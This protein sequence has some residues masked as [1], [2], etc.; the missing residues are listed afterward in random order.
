MRSLIRLSGTFSRGEK[1]R[2]HGGFDDAPIESLAD[3]IGGDETEAFERAVSGERGGVVPPVHDEIGRLGDFRPARTQG[4]GI[5]IAKCGAHRAGTDKRRIAHHEIR[6]RPCRL[7]RVHITLQRH[8]GAVIGDGESSHWRGFGGDAIPAHMRHAVFIGEVFH[9]V[10]SQHG[11][12]V[13][14]IA[15][16]ADHRLRRRDVALGAEVPLQVADPQHHFSDGGGT[17]IQFDTEQLVRIDGF[18]AGRIGA[19]AIDGEAALAEADFIECVEHFAFEAFQVFEGDIE[20]IARAAGRI[21]HVQRAQAMVKTAQHADRLLLLAFGGQGEGG[22][23]GIAPL[24]AQRFDH[25][26]QHE[27]LDIGAR[28]VVRAELVPLARI[29][30]AFEQGAEDGRFDV[31][32][33]GACRFDQQGDLFAAQ[34]QRVRTLE[35]LAVESEHIVGDGG[36]ESALVHVLPED[37]EHAHGG[38]RILRMLDQQ[39]AE[40]LRRQQ[41]H[42]LGEHREQAAHE[43][44]RDEFGIMPGRFETAREGGEARGDLAGDAGGF[45]R[46]IQR[47]RFQPDA[48][49]AFADFRLAQILKRNAMAARIREWRVGGPRAGEL[50]EQFD[51]LTDIDDDQERR[52]TFAGGQRTRIGLGLAARTQDGII[53]S[54]RMGAGLEFF[55][56]EHERAAPIQIDAPGAAAAIAM[57]KGDRALEHVGLLGVRMRRLDA[58]QVA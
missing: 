40:A 18:G 15:E 26:R 23:L 12:A 43:E 29:Q 6:L 46:G 55:R 52:A 17:R 21:E 45:T 3:R 53:E 58:E 44:L 35:Q 8:A 25:G 41:L 27:A 54:A 50:G 38:W 34:R 11:I 56:F 9:V 33:F 47:Q 48:A 10:V 30:R 20:E 51:A 1:G 24:G 36:R 16:I 22:G 37:G 49:Q 19:L 31:L 42:I 2:S 57:R 32:P 13:F 28:R 7:A 4:F 5:A 14:D 39:L